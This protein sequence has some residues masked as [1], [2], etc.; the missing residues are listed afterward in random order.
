MY[1]H[2]DQETKNQIG[3]YFKQNTKNM[4]FVYITQNF[5]R[6]GW[7]LLFE[8]LLD[9][10]FAINKMF[11]DRHHGFIPEIDAGWCATPYTVLSSLTK[12]HVYVYIIFR[13]LI[14][15]VTK[16]K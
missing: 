4:K 12:L 13:S 1:L 7:F 16:H 5:M 10:H 15:V 2:K 8:D 14:F 9:F 6:A 11:N 3:H